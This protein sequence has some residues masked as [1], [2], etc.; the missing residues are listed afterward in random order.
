MDFIIHQ[1]EAANQQKSNPQTQRDQSY[2]QSSPQQKEGHDVLINGMPLWQQ[3]PYYYPESSYVRSHVDESSPL[4]NNS[5]LI[6]Q[7]GIERRLMTNDIDGAQ[8]R[9]L[10][11][12]KGRK[13][14]DFFY[15]NS[16]MNEIYNKVGFQRLNDPIA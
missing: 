12:L 11:I 10:S 9:N 16:D 7:K 1:H 14:K 8:P 4:K 5:K 15:E 3:A 2:Q 6:L 13:H